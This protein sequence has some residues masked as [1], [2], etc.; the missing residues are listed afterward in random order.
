MSKTNTLNT[1]TQSKIKR[2]AYILEIASENTNATIVEHLANS[3]EATL[4]DLIILTGTEAPDLEIR[5]ER[6]C[7]IGL[8]QIRNTSYSSSYRLNNDG[9]NRIQRFVKVL[10]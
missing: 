6:L 5:L 4:S 3:F 1:S 9:W 7:S 8:V 10:V 2:A